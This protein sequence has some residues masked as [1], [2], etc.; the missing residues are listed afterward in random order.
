MILLVGFHACAP[1]THQNNLLCRACSVCDLVKSR[2]RDAP[3]GAVMRPPVNTRH[4]D[5]GC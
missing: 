5:P 4:S 2:G 3:P 1:P